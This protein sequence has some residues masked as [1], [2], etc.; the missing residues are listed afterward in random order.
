MSSSVVAIVVTRDRPQLLQEC[1]RAILRQTRRPERILV[2]DNDSGIET[3]NVLSTFETSVEVVRSDVNVGG[4]GGFAA[5]LD[6]ALLGKFNWAWVMDDDSLPADDC[7]SKLLLA[8][9]KLPADVGF[10]APVVR[11]PEGQNL[12]THA[13]VVP[14]PSENR[15]IAA[16]GD[17]VGA[18]AATFVGPMINLDVA[19]STWLPIADFFLWWDDFEYTSRLQS[20][21]GGAVAKTARMTHPEKSTHTDMGERLFFDLRGRLWMAK[22][23]HLASPQARREAARWIWFRV[24][25]QFRYSKSKRAYFKALVRGFA[26]GL[27]TSPRLVRPKL[28]SRSEDAPAAPESLSQPGK[29]RKLSRLVPGHRQLGDR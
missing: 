9:Q 1:L 12:D 28:H 20:I 23:R 16:V 22:G 17:V 10:I 25:T 29:L 14:E 4:A 24:R 13:V 18:Q 7:L 2:Y 11:G 6:R 27:F 19:K 5:S 26:A 8:S 15:G 3:Q 21:A